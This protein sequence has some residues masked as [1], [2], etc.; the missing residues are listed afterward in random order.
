MGNCQVANVL[1]QHIAFPQPI[2]STKIEENK[3]LNLKEV[4]ALNDEIHLQE[5][6]QTVQLGSGQI[7]AEAQLNNSQI[8]SL[9]QNIESNNINEAILNGNLLINSIGRNTELLSE[10]TLNSNNYNNNT[11]TDFDDSLEG[12]ENDQNKRVSCRSKVNFSKLN[13]SEKVL[14]LQNM[15][16][17]IKKLKQQV[18]QLKQKKTKGIYKYK[19]DKLPT[20]GDFSRLVMTR[21]TPVISHAVVP[22]L[23]YLNTNQQQSQQIYQNSYH[24][25]QFENS[26]YRSGEQQQQ[27][28]NNVPLNEMNLLQKLCPNQ[29]QPLTENQLTGRFG[30][31]FQG[32]NSTIGISLSQQDSSQLNQGQDSDKLRQQLYQ[33]KDG[34]FGLDAQNPGANQ[35]TKNVMINSQMN[36]QQNHQNIFSQNNFNPSLTQFRNINTHQMQPYLVGQP[37]SNQQ[38]MN[39]QHT[40]E[41][42]RFANQAAPIGAGISCQT[43]IFAKPIPSPNTFNYSNIQSVQQQ[44]FQP[45]F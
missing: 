36:P 8:Q 39:Q 12:S 11:D 29:L 33:Y 27:S 13:E 40:S 24:P 14:R 5:S 20:I 18:R 28:K 41:N 30:G 34:Y 31:F 22:S 1:Q 38:L 32:N 10:K 17:L 3:D 6:I 37:Q 44:F 45:R 35:Q 4:T 43:G 9:G 25:T 15:A 42:T 16:N 23:K 21:K 7:N 19:S 26:G 2:D